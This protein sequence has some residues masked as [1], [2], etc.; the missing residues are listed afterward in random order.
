MEFFPWAEKIIGRE[1]ER[2]RLVAAGIAPEKALVAQQPVPLRLKGLSHQNSRGEI[3]EA[4]EE[5]QIANIVAPA[6]MIA[7][8]FMMIMIGASPAMQSVLEE[9]MQRIAEVLLGSVR[10]FDLMLGKLIGMVGVSLT[11]AV[12]YLGG[13]YIVAYQYGFTDF[14][15]PYLLAWFLIF[16][17]LAV[18]MYGSLFIAVGA[19]ANDMKETQGL[20]LPVMVVAILPLMLLGPVMMDSNSTL[21]TVLSFIPTATPMLMIAR[22]AV[23]P[24]VPWWQPL[25][26]IVGVLAATLGCVYAAG[27]IFRVGILM[28][29][30]GV[31]LSDLVK[32]VVR[33]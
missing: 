28:Q 19:A 10:P 32:W 17:I 3:E 5:R 22:I 16:L 9:K 33:G 13:A 8:M 1:V 21:A 29:G 2:R 24:G 7:L 27:R 20:L 4:S 14:L 6:V 12:V 31:R 25:A 30:K 26:G 18:L 15:S 11:V 23:P